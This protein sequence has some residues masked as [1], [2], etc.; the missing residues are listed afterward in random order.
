MGGYA[1]PHGSQL[2]G[3]SMAGTTALGNTFV[4]VFR[5]LRASCWCVALPVSPV[6]RR[7]DVAA[8]SDDAAAGAML[9]CTTA[10]L[11]SGVGAAGQA[12]VVVEPLF[13]L[14]CGRSGCV[15]VSLPR[16]QRWRK[17]HTVFR[18]PSPEQDWC[19]SL[20]AARLRARRVWATNRWTAAEQGATLND[21]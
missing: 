21:H 7:G 12:T 8:S 17:G 9:R 5:P 1:T 16:P 2:I 20:L 14:V 11:R 18:V 10:I 6:R 3:V 15:L 13:A 19:A 4:V